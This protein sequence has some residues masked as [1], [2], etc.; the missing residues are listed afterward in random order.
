MNSMVVIN[1]VIAIV[2]FV[3]GIRLGVFLGEGRPLDLKT[4][5]IYHRVDMSPGNAFLR[6]EEEKEAKLYSLKDL[7]GN[8]NI[9]RVPEGFILK[10]TK[11]GL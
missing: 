1:V 3:I 10:K 7:D 6:R 8:I 5:T 2:A 11:N 9:K 4:N